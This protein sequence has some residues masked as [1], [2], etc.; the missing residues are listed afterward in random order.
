ML[1]QIRR[2]NIRNYTIFLRDGVLFSYFEYIGTDYE[3]DMA[4]MAADDQTQR[5][6]ADR[7]LPAAC[8]RHSRRCAVGAAGGGVPQ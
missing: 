8:R 5:W 3:A 2:S 4:A 6:W 7:P 1:E